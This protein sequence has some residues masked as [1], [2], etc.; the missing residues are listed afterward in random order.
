MLW[1]SRNILKK[2]KIS[3]LIDLKLNWPEEL[4]T[5]K[6]LVT[7]NI[8]IAQIRKVSWKNYCQLGNK[9]K[10]NSQLKLEYKQKDHCFQFLLLVRKH[11]LTEINLWKYCSYLSISLVVLRLP[12]HLIKNKPIKFSNIRWNQIEVDRYKKWEK[13]LSFISENYKNLNKL[14]AGFEKLILN[15]NQILL[16]VTKNIRQWLSTFPFKIDL[17]SENPVLC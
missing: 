10:I 6:E 1:K 2:C 4:C 17:L 12:S 16:M 15:N 9:I 7:T 13:L 3:N 5:V 8:W 11:V 14:K